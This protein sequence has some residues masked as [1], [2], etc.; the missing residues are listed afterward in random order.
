MWKKKKKTETETEVHT[1]GG[2][3]FLVAGES[4]L[5]QDVRFMTLIKRAG[6]DHMTMNEGEAPEDFARRLLDQTI[7]SGTVLDLLSC[8]LIPKEEAPRD[9][10]PGEAWN[11]EMAQAT[12]AFLA[13]LKKPRDKVKFRSL[14]I[15][16]LLYF[17]EHGIVCL[18][19]SKTSLNGAIPNAEGES[20]GQPMQDMA[21][22]PT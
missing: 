22:G 4:T 12:A 10:D 8:L 16:L 1:L 3:D 11:P 14:V 2:R 6:I 15:S 5:G 18:Y 9:R 20:A 19:V 13:G 17:F 21:D 7:E